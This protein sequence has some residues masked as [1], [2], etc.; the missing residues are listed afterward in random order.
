MASAV[1]ILDAKGK[2]LIA[3]DFRGDI[4]LKT[5]EKFINYLVEEDEITK[6][7]VFEVDG[8]SYAYTTHN[9]LYCNIQTKKSF[10]SYF[11]SYLFPFF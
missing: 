11:F 2:L 7:P 8:V 10:H 3:R 5:S 4:S 1:F 6:K 9:G